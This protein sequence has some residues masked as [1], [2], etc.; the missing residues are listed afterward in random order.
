M[1]TLSKATV[2]NTLRLLVEKGAVLQLTIDERKTCYDGDTS[3]HAHFLCRCC[4]RVYDVPV[5]RPN[6]LRDAQLPEGFQA[7][8]VELY[9]K[10]ICPHCR[11]EAN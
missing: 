3:P 5:K 11:K 1:P 9:I 6:L 10:G 7:D 8:Q 2:Y 4:S